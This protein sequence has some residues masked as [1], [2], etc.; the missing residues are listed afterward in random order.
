M[1]LIIHQ[2]LGLGDMILCNGLIRHILNQKS[3]NEK[4]LLICKD[5]HFNT[6]KFMY[7]DESRIKLLKISSKNNENDEVQKYLIKDKFKKNDFLRIGHEFYQ[8]TS[9]LNLD[10]SNEWPCDVVFYKQLN[11]PFKY[12]F[13]KTFWKRDMKK[14][15]FL[16]KKLVK[17]INNYVFIHDDIN[18]N[19][20]IDD[21][22]INKKFQ[23]I[24]NNLKYKIFDYGL[25]L[26]NAKELH[27]MES[28]FR[29]VIET[30]NMKNKKLILYKGRS[31]HHSINLYN[32]TANQ[33]IGTSKKWIINKYNIETDGDEKRSFL[34]YWYKKLTT[35]FKYS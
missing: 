4:I 17:N 28:S 26:E 35:L 22:N 19:L 23:I 30:L 20:K 5:I 14:E 12:R 9:N 11:V 10:K 3:K 25:I 29:Q 34:F 31:G 24:R 2:H 1:D 15:K 21:S 32:K 6:V 13:T 7:R 18:R 8:P 16:F 27:L 33:W